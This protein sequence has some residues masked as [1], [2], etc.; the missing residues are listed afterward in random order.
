MRTSNRDVSISR[1]RLKMLRSVPPT[2]S[3]PVKS[4]T[5]ALVPMRTHQVLRSVARPLVPEPIRL[6]LL[7][8]CC[9]NTPSSLESMGSVHPKISRPMCPPWFKRR[10][11]TDL[12]CLSRAPQE[13]SNSLIA[14]A[15]YP[16]GSHRPPHS[17]PDARSGFLPAGRD[18]RHV[19]ICQHMETL[20]ESHPFGHK[21]CPSPFA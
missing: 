15:H 20:A 6:R 18:K 8:E 3:E 1:A 5:L 12:S 19:Q 13:R 16:V 11:C 9:L 7:I 10:L 14:E 21:G 17:S 2:P 4:M